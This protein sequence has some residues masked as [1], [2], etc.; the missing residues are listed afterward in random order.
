MS[1]INYSFTGQTNCSPHKVVSL[2]PFLKSTQLPFKWWAEGGLIW[3]ADPNKP[4]QKPTYAQ[5]QDAL[6]R[7]S[8]GIKVWLPDIKEHPNHYVVTIQQVADFF[9]RFV[10]D[11][12]YE[13]LRQDENAGNIVA[14][15]RKD[16]EIGKQAKVR[17]EAIEKE[18]AKDKKTKLFEYGTVNERVETNHLITNVY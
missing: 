15:Y 2:P 8:T 18:R 5:P 7:V 9:D 17:A 10:K 11:V 1:I 12:Y 4:D 13:A 6:L 14:N 16:Y 3:C